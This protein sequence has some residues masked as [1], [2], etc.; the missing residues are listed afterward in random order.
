VKV[1]ATGKLST[2]TENLDLMLGRQG[3]VVLVNGREHPSMVVAAGTRE[4]WRFVN[5]ANG[6]RASAL[7]AARPSALD[8]ELGRIHWLA[9]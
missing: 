3:N 7:P 9:K 5:A 8:R 1:E 6:Y 2:T 4:R